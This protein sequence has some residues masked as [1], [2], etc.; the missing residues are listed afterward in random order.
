[1]RIETDSLGPKPVPAAAYYGVQTV[2]ALENFP[3]SGRRFAPPILRA[4]GLIK[5]AAATS[6]LTLKQLDARRGRAIRQAAEDLLANRRG[7]QD[8]IVVDVYQAGAGTSLN[9]NVNEVLANRANERLGGRRG[10]YRPV[11]PNDH[12]NMAQSTNDVIPAAIR[13]SA[14]MTL[15]DLLAALD[16]LTAALGRKASAFDAIVKSGRTHLQDAVP[17]RLGQEFGGYAHVIAKQRRRLAAARDGLL[18][19]NLGATAAGTGLNAHPRYRATVAKVLARRTRLPVRPADDLFEVTQSLGDIVAV[20]SALRG[21]ALELT[22]IA[23]DLRLLS[24]GPR[25]GL[26]EI[27]LPAVQ[28]GSSIMPGKVNPVMAELLNQVCFQ[29]IGCDTT[30]AYAAQAG[31]LELNVMMPVVA[32]NLI[33]STTIL[34]NALRVFT[35][36]CVAGIT[37]DARRCRDYADHSVGLA[38]ALNP[39]LGYG[40]AAALVKEAV[41]TGRSIREIMEQRGLMNDPRIAHLLD[42]PFALTGPKRSR[43]RKGRA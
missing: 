33:F 31:Q 32:H 18:E 1:M 5:W 17:V 7:L 42:D 30:V 21:L 19:L 37:A 4:L 13:L 41:A 39:S 3:I 38:T 16:Q 26:A 34:T 29:V 6:N 43:T 20:S 25:T 8:Q 35:T 12:V 24:S 28:P 36:K 27:T 22:K 40:Q 9:M 11:H 2:R 10:A 14:L 15:P 23:N